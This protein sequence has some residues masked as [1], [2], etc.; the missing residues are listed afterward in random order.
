MKHFMA[1]YIHGL[2]ESNNSLCH[3][4]NPSLSSGIGKLPINECWQEIWV[5]DEQDATNVK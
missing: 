1:G 3:L 2:L 4:R 5:N